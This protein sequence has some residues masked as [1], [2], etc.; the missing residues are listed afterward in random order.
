MVRRLVNCLVN[1][2][3]SSLSDLFEESES[4]VAFLLLL[5]EITDTRFSFGLNLAVRIVSLIIFGCGRVIGDVKLIV[6]GV[7]FV[8]RG[9]VCFAIV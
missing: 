7:L 2:A 1:Y 9:S 5:L 6:E 3:V 8:E 4:L